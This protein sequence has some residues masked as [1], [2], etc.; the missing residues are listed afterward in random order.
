MTPTSNYLQVSKWGQCTH[1][2]NFY[3]GEHY[4]GAAWQ[5]PPLGEGLDEIN[6]AA[7]ECVGKR[8]W[9]GERA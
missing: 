6:P 9:K 1:C 2:F 7:A 4:C 5:K 3:T 8:L